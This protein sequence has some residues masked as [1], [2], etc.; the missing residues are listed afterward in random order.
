MQKLAPFMR[1]MPPER[2]RALAG[3]RGI[4]EIESRE[5][6]AVGKTFQVQVFR[7]TGAAVSR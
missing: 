2:L 6:S 3:R 4:E 5:E 1:L 7:R